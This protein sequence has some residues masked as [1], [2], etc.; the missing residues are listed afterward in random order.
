MKIAIVAAEL[1]PYAK[2]GGLADVIGALPQ[3]LKRAGAEPCVIVPGYQALLRKLKIE[4]FAENQAIMLDKVQ[5]R[6][7]ILRAEGSGGVPLY[8][9]DHPGFFDREGIYGDRH[10]DYS[11]NIRRF[12]FFGRAAAATAA[13]AHP[14]VL[15]AHD[16]HTAAASI[17]IR[18]NASL[19][20]QF[21][22]TSSFFTFHNLAFQG[23]FERDQFPLLG[24]DE[25]WF[26]MD[27]L[28]FYGRVNLMKG[29]LVLADAASTVSP[30]YAFEVSHDPDL[31]FGLDGVLRAKAGR[32]IGILNGADYDEWNPATDQLIG[33]RYSPERRNG[34]K[35]CLYDLREETG[36]PH[37]RETPIIAMVTRMTAQKGVDLLAEALKSIIQHNVQIVM[38]ASGDPGLEEFFKQAER[39]YPENLRVKLG[40]DNALAHRMQAGSDLFLMPSRFEPC[41]LTQMYALKYGVAPIVRATGGLRD[42]VVEFDP[43]SLKGNG[44]VFEEADPTALAN[45]V[46][47]AA[48][49]FRNPR[50]WQRLMDNCFRAD[51]SWARAAGEYL[52]WF[53]RVRSER[54]AA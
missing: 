44:F 48:R 21:E 27:Y 25:S 41:G 31:G 34:K 17:A 4:P 8:L 38:L 12:V 24:I 7:R 43:R 32:F 5:E 2:A 36:L 50:L 20:S 13:M 19:R 22:A 45:A 10:G 14:D 42:T 49:T 33:T 1:G 35:A 6:F 40:F 47:R 54:V 29:A 28:E 16:W 39:R 18:A 15:H 11:D 9:V 23:I 30:S 52:D 51:F 37:R 46:E 53:K 26:S 3:A